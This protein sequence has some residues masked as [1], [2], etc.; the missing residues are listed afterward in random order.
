MRHA[1]AALGLAMLCIGASPQPADVK[2]IELHGPDGQRVFV[3]EHD[4]SSLREPTAI[5]MRRYFTAGARCV[6]VTT[7]GKFTAV[8][9]GCAQIRDMM[10]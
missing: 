7:S 3:A 4:I 10:R 2:L 6:V 5:D 8:V 9:E 1:W